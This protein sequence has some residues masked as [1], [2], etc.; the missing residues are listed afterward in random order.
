MGTKIRP[1]NLHTTVDSHVKGLIDSA[2]VNARVSTVDSAQVQSIIDSDY[3]KTTLKV[4]SENTMF[5][6]IAT[7][8][9]TSFTGNDANS[10]SLAYNPASTQV[11]L[12]GSLLTPTVD[13]GVD[14][15]DT[16]TLVSGA[17]LGSELIVNTFK[18]GVITPSNSLSLSGGT[19]TGNLI[20]GDNKKILLGNDSDFEIVHNASNSIINDKGTG[21]LQLQLG[22]STKL[23]ITS[24]GITVTGAITGTLAT[25][26]QANITSVGT[27]TGLSVSGNV[28]L[29]GAATSSY[30]QGVTGGKT[31]TIGDGSQASSTLVLKDD[32][33]V[34]D[35]A[36]TGGTLR[37]YDDNT[38]RI[39]V[40]ASGNVLI[41]TSNSNP[42]EGNV[43][44]IG[45]LAGNSIS[46]TDDG[47][48][49]IQLNR[50]S[51]DGA[52]AIF[53]KN[54]SSVGNITYSSAT[55][56]AIGNTSKGLGIGS[57][58]IFPTNG[59]TA[60][61]DAGLDLGYSSSRFGDLYLSGGLLVGGT[62]TSNKLDDYEEGT[63]TPVMEGTSSTPSITYTRQSGYY[64]KI[65]KQVTWI[66]DIRFSAW[67]GGSGTL[68]INQLPFTSN[69]MAG[70]DYQGNVHS[71]Y[72]Y[73]GTQPTNGGGYHLTGENK[74]YFVR[75]SDGYTAVTANSINNTSGHLMLGGT[76]FTNS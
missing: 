62:T 18:D 52:I 29:G 54:G 1:F 23:S 58:S 25:A 21:D 15:G 45:L 28:G 14:S 69:G 47:G 31:V 35:I 34:F 13:Y 64:T 33:G 40:D 36:T 46:V 5:R 11:F 37:I 10:S 71:S 53:R 26:A 56:I 59:S 73:Q 72:M 38:E 16:I 66:V 3:V 74:A 27:L 39:R 22:G 75:A 61:S 70:G 44:G 43:A 57:S 65:G 32:D 6:Y 63:F 67:T 41:G 49:P 68:R 19:L 8:N 2:Y 60:I 48:A 55:N 42:A 24:A 30:L 20:L 12:N 17:A 4:S 9:Q 51:S 7:A 76:F 50:K